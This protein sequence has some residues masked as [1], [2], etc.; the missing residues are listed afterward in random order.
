MGGSGAAANLSGKT[1]TNQNSSGRENY[2]IDTNNTDPNKG[3]M[4]NNPALY[5][6]KELF[7]LL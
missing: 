6:D 2:N 7:N 4:S 3:P 5:D 1:G